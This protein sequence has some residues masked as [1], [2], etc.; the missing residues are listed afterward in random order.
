MLCLDEG[1]IAVY[2]RLAAAF[3]AAGLGAEV[4]PSAKKL[5]AQF[6]YAER[7][8]IPLTLFHGEA[9][10]TAGLCNLR[11]LRSRRSFDGLT[12]QEAVQT[13]SELLQP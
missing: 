2:H 7:R 13:A 5:P 9:E 10:R 4:Y 1:L 12:V 11:D 6:K 3:R 8:G